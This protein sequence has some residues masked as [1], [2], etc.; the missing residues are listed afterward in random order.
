MEAEERKKKS[1]EVT[2]EEWS[3]SSSS[4]LSRTA[5]ITSLSIQRSSP[6][7]F[8]FFFFTPLHFQFSFSISLHN[9][10]YFLLFLISFPRRADLAVSSPMYGG[11]FSRLLYRRQVPVLCFGFLIYVITYLDF[12][13]LGHFLEIIFLNLDA[14]SFIWLL[15]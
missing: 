10:S 14:N 1:R 7:F 5:T 13:K 2:V 12:V 8:F 9:P 6:F 3:G 15:P 4:K 11:G